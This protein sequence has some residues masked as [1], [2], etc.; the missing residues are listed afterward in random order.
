[1]LD[2][3]ARVTDQIIAPDGLRER[4][5]SGRQLRLKYGVD[6]TAPDLHIGHAVNLWMYERL[7]QLGHKVLFLLGDFTTSVG[8]PTGRSETRP[9]LRPEQ[10]EANAEAIQREALS[11]LQ[12]GSDV[13]EIRR[14]SEW[15]RAMPTREFLSILSLITQDQLMA[16]DMFRTRQMEGTRIY[17]HEFVYPVL[18]GYDS[19][20]LE[21]D[22]TIIGTDQL[23]NEMMGRSLQEKFGQAPQVVVTTVITAGL[24]GGEKQ[25]KSLGNYIGLSHSPRDKFGRA[26]RLRDDLLG[27]FLTVYT[28]LPLSRV[29]EIMALAQQDPMEAKLQFAESL[30]GRYHGPATAARER[31]WFERRFRHRI[32]PDDVRVIRAP[33]ATLPALELLRLVPEFATASNSDL[34]RRLEQGSVRVDGEKLEGDPRADVALKSDGSIVQVGK[35]RVFRFVPADGSPS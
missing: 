18:Q 2:D 35:R 27:E 29:R 30:V 10:I 14:N 16:R 34:R 20:M 26:M 13:L 11:V 31:E 9:V 24:D 12:T 8:D 32:I 25:S 21:A 22:A 28:D 15:Y 33:A 3:F 1:L 17:M 23:Y 5:L 7:Q 19:V 4:L 6:L